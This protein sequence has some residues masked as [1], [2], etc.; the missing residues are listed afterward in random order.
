VIRRTGEVDYK[1][2]DISRKE[3]VV[4]INRLKL[5]RNPEV[6]KP[7]ITRPRP[8]SRVREPSVGKERE[9][10]VIFPSREILEPLPQGGNPDETPNTPNQDSPDNLETPVREE[11][12]PEPLRNDQYYSPSRTPRSRF[13]LRNTRDKPPTPEQ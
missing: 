12:T 11:E 9:E 7:K 8:S 1:I 4:H 3:S 6:W 2:R 5:A 10:Q 13:E